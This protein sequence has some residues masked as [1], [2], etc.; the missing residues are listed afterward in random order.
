ML[1]VWEFYGKNEVFPNE[2]NY[3]WLN[4]WDYSAVRDDEA[5]AYQ[6]G[7]KGTNDDCEETGRDDNMGMYCL[8]EDIE[9]KIWYF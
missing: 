8:R 1:E 7:W 4:M 6:Y 9:H 2:K 5:R 3:G